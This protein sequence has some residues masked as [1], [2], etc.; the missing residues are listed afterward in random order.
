MLQL[1]SELKIFL[2][3]RQCQIGKIIAENKLKETEKYLT[4]NFAA[5]S[6]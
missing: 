5:K 1:K 6:A 2:L 3:N 4:D